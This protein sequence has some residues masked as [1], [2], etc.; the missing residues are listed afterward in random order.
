MLENANSSQSLGIDNWNGSQFVFEWQMKCSNL[1][2]LSYDEIMR[3]ALE[4]I[5]LEDKAI[6][7]AEE[8]QW[9]ADH[10]ILATSESFESICRV[11]IRLNT[12]DSFVY[13]LVNATLRDND[14]SKV[15][16]REFQN[17][18]F[19]GHVYRRVEQ[20]PVMVIEYK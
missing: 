7:H 19:T 17:L 13:R 2:S 6:G 20:T 11:C 9:I 4:E 8:A 12:M 10:R 5:R 15:D 16:T 14:L 18:H 1:E 3:Q